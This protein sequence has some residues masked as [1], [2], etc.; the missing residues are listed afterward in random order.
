[1]EITGRIVGTRALLPWP[2]GRDRLLLLFSRRND[3]PDRLLVSKKNRQKLLP[4]KNVRPAT[5]APPCLLRVTL[6]DKTVP[7]FS[8]LFCRLLSSSKNKLLT[9]PI[10]GPCHLAAI[11][12]VWSQHSS[13]RPTANIR[14]TQ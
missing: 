4:L 2:G 10:K 9:K 3:P 5:Q 13:L 6:A 14:E 1:M 11:S 8:G 12:K 7:S